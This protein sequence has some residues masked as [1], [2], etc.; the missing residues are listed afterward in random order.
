[1]AYLDIHGIKNAFAN[2]LK[3]YCGY[4]EQ[5]VAIAVSDFPDPY[6]LPYLDEEYIGEEEIDGIKYQKNA[7]YTSFWKCGM[8]WVPMFRFYTYYAVDDVPNS[9]VSEYMAAR[10]LFKVDNLDDGDF[11]SKEDVEASSTFFF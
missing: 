10:K 9:L 4:S 8:A 3:A 2:H 6:R 1:M 11:P 5:E 7:S